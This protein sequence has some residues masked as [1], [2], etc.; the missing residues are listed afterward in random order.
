MYYLCWNCHYYLHSLFRFFCIF[1][2]ILVEMIFHSSIQVDFM[3]QILPLRAG[4]SFLL[5]LHKFWGS[6]DGRPDQP[7][8]RLRNGQTTQIRGRFQLLDSLLYF[9][10]QKESLSVEICPSGNL[11][12]S[13]FLQDNLSSQN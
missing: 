3:R 1:K 6:R 13:L 10:A 4:H 2:Y 7:V 9:I 5:P 12:F 8:R 11:T